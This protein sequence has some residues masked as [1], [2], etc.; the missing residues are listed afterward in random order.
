MLTFLSC[1]MINQEPTINDDLPGRILQGAVQ[2]KPNLQEFR[3]ST[4]VF[5]N[6]TIEDG[7]DAVVFCTGYQTYFP[8][9]LPSKTNDP[10]GEISLYRRVFPLYL[11]HCTLAFIGFINSRGPLIPVMEMQAR[12]ATRVFSGTIETV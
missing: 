8:F 2:M 10:M 6:E 3:G 4:V 12:W 9:L 1:R 5:D 7:I 11:E